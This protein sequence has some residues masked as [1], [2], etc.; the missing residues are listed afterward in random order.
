MYYRGESNPGHVQADLALGGD[1]AD[2]GSGRRRRR[3]GG[4]EDEFGDVLR[5]VGRGSA[6]PGATDGYEELRERSKKTDAFSRSRERRK[7]DT[8]PVPDEGER[9]R[10]RSRFDLDA[11][12]TKKKLNRR[13]K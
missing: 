9:M 13:T 1:L 4:L 12:A 2:Y 7:R 8:S 3:A 5:G 6:H 11:K 10:K